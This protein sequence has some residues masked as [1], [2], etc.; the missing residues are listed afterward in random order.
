MDDNVELHRR[1]VEAFNTRDIEAMVVLCTP[2]VEL[3]SAV[4]QAGGAIYHGH[5]GV[6]QWHRDLQDGWGDELWM[7][8]EAFYAVGEATMTFHVLHGRGTQSGAPVAM[9]AAHVC[10]WR[11]GLMTY[12]K[13]Y[14]RREE[15]F[16]DLGVAQGTLES[17]PP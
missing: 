5:D 17:L 9:P 1:S 13:G 3:H 8:P 14:A 4:T 15:A 10:R 6:R 12:F 7:E 11:D 16:A 2:D